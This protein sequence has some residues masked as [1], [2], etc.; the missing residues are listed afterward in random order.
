MIVAPLEC[1]PCLCRMAVDQ[2]G[3]SKCP[4]P[5][6]RAAV[7]AS[8]YMLA[9]VDPLTPTGV[10][11]SEIYRSVG[12]STGDVDP[13]RSLKT[14]L[15]A[16]AWSV[17]SLLRSRVEESQDPFATAV[18]ISLA[19]NA[20]GEARSVRGVAKSVR[21]AWKLATGDTVPGAE[22]EALRAASESATKV[23][24]MADNVGEI[25]WDTLLIER[26]SHTAVT[27]LVRRE[28]FWQ[29]AQI[30][31]AIDAGLG[32]RA[33][34]AEHTRYTT[35]HVSCVADCPLDAWLDTFD[36]IVAKGPENLTFLEGRAQDPRHFALLV[37]QCSRLADPLGIVPGRPALIHLSQ[38][39]MANGV[40]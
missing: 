17:M 33:K 35:V 2:A 19:G 4:D 26:L 10:L 11:A 39:E 30:A 13:C 34:L 31:D 18:Q 8:L 20:L 21:H 38:L 28:P 1:L 37:P 24:F 40:S 5:A 36:L 6:R 32:S 29:D 16:A 9:M 14:R 25:L 23:L 12:G 15:R 27:V 7:E 3:L 22:I